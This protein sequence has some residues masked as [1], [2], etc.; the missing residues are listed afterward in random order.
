MTRIILLLVLFSSKLIWSQ[1]F[2]KID[3]LIENSIKLK[4]FPGA[5]VYLKNLD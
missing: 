3:S 2:E 1:N 5:Q 4:A